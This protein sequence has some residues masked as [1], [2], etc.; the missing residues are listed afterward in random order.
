MPDHAN[1]SNC[2]LK[3]DHV[4]TT[5]Y[6]T[7]VGHIFERHVVQT[8]LKLNRARIRI[9]SVTHVLFKASIV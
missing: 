2:K 8:Q 9:V 7:V 1:F 5:I 3:K 6:R 4:E